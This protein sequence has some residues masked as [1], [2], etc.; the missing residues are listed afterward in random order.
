MRYQDVWIVVPAYQEATVIGDVI[1]DV[2]SVFGHVVCVDDGSDDGTGDAA[3]RAGTSTY[4][5]AKANR[6]WTESIPAPGRVLLP[7]I[8]SHF[9]HRRNPP[10][11]RAHS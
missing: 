7:L 3:L 1:A 10:R 6:R 5:A 9:G 8:A 2:R 11:H 4:T